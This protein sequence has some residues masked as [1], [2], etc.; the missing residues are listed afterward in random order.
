MQRNVTERKIFLFVSYMS[1]NTNK[2]VRRHIP[3][4]KIKVNP[5]EYF[6]SLH[7]GTYVLSPDGDRPEC[8]RHYEAIG[9]GTM[10]ITGLDPYLHRH[11]LGNVIFK[12]QRWVLKELENKLP[13]T[14]RVNRRLI[15]E[16]FW[17][18]YAERVIGRPMRWW[19]PSRNVR[20]S[21]AEITETVKNTSLLEI[22]ERV[23]DPFST[24][25]VEADEMR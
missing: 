7:N 10:P 23:K 11:L 1:K 4:S 3:R 12:E 24:L 22:G 5:P 8:H 6:Q 2:E 13:K 16:E 19:D 17:M 20:C 9:M 15:F 25:H 18:E 14:P 21:L